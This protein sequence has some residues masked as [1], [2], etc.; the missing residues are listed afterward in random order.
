VLVNPSN[1]SN[2]AKLSDI[3]IAV[4]FDR[5]TMTMGAAPAPELEPSSEQLSA[6]NQLIVGGDSPYV[7]FSIFVPFGRRFLKKL[8]MQ[9]SHFVPELGTWKTVEQPGPPDFNSWLKSWNV[10]KTTL[11]LLDIAKPAQLDSYAEIIR[12]Q[13]EEHGPTCW[14]IIYQAD[15]RMRS[16][17][18]DRI[19]RRMS[20][21]FYKLDQAAKL[22]SHFNPADPWNIIFQLSHPD[23]SHKADRFWQV[24]VKDKCTAYLTQIRTWNQVMDDGTPNNPGPGHQSLLQGGKR[25]RL[26]N[27]YKTSSWSAT[28][29]A[30]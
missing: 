6:V 3:D 16:E 23:A 25:Q 8:S 17:E 7:D 19:R 4:M 15:V 2:L 26:Q 30:A 1:K 5:Y 29:Q 10:F 24:E 14:S 28:P 27:N 21:D 13:S 9:A 22:L 11:L 20:I 18:F 12:K